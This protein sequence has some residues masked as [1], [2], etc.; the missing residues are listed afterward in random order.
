VLV[1]STQGKG[2]VFR[3]QVQIPAAPLAAPAI[4]APPV[5]LPAAPLKAEGAGVTILVIEDDPSVRDL[6]AL[7]LDIDG[8]SVTSVADGAAA[9]ALVETGQL[10]PVLILTDYNLP[11]H[12][13]GVETTVRLRAALRRSVPAIVLTGDISKDTLRQIA[14]N[15]CVQLNKPIKPAELMAMIGRLLRQSA[16]ARPAAVAPVRA[17]AKAGAAVHVIDDDAGVRAAIR[18]VLEQEGYQVCSY[19][20]AEEFLE[21]G[22]QLLEGCLLVD[23]YLPGLSGLELLARLGAHLQVL[24]AIMIT[25]SAF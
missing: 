20:S 15:G 8:H 2:S 17:P 5:S 1:T 24:P 3:I 4:P 19:E 21:M 7:L 25:L 11:G 16:L 9:L 18:L 6:L 23:A 13:D 22:G 12:L 10:F 14:E